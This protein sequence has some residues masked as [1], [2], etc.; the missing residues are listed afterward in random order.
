MTDLHV[1]SYSGFYLSHLSA[2]ETK[3]IFLEDGKLLKET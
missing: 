1:V 3:Y 2:A